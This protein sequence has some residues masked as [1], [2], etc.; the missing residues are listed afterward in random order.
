[1]KKKT[2]FSKATAMIENIR[3]EFKSIVSELDWMDNPSKTAAKDKADYI[4]PK[5]G[6]P[7]FTYN[8]T[9]LNELY[10]YV[11]RI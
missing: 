10:K 7:D 11:T 4:E 2:T 9:Y 6:Y 1:M 3:S 5:I 8:D